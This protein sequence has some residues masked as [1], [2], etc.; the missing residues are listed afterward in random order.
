MENSST[1]GGVKTACNTVHNEKKNNLMDK[2]NKYLFT[3]M[4]LIGIF[5]FAAHYLRYQQDV[6]FEKDGYQ[7]VKVDKSQTVS[8]HKEPIVF[9]IETNSNKKE[10]YKFDGYENGDFGTYNYYY[11][12][13]DS[14]QTDNNFYFIEGFKNNLPFQK[15]LENLTFEERYD[16]VNSGT[17]FEARQ[18]IQHNLE[19][20]IFGYIDTMPLIFLVLGFVVFIILKVV[21]LIEYALVKNF[22]KK[23]VEIIIQSVMVLFL[24]FFL[25]IVRITPWF[26]SSQIAL[27]IRNAIVVFPIFVLFQWVKNKFYN[28]KEFWK[29]QL[30]TFLI[31]FIGG[32]LLLWIGNEIGYLIDKNTFEKI[33][34]LPFFCTYNSMA[35]GFLMSFT[36][37]LTLNNF[38]NAIVSKRNEHYAQQSIKR[39]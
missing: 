2:S 12:K 34:H 8:P 39:S 26:P 36:I 14:I 16:I 24:V 28:D 4:L 15:K 7:I 23:R 38:I 31:I 22:K 5:L 37:G 30:M 11:F 29:N 13:P 17:N 1:S 6:I 19:S 3:I 9:V 35:I 33:I 10:V 20:G 18:L 25:T 32:N 21:D 27:L